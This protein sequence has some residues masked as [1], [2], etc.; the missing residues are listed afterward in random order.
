M[1]WAGELFWPLA[2]LLTA[3]LMTRPPRQRAPRPRG[4]RR[5]CAARR[6]LAVLAR[7]P[8]TFAQLLLLSLLAFLLIDVGA[9]LIAQSFT[10]PNV[11]L[12]VT[13]AQMTMGLVAGYTA[14]LISV[15]ARRPRAVGV[16][17]RGRAL[18]VGGSASRRRPRSRSS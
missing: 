9:Y 18:R 11:I 3:Y 12:N 6:A 2:I 13:F 1:G 14:R 17:L 5:L 10:S 7:R 4:G 16:G 8:A 15:H